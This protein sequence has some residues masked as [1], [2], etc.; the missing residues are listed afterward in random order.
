MEYPE[1]WSFLLLAAKCPT[2]VKNLEFKHLLHTMD[3]QYQ[4]PNR[5]AIRKEIDKVL[6]EL[7]AKISSYSQEANK[8]SICADIWSKRGMSSS[9]L[10][11]TCHFYSRRDHFF[12]QQTSL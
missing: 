12:N 8:V 4:M 1:S 5:S 6:I 11:I 9:Y 10:G 3:S 2:V 7:N